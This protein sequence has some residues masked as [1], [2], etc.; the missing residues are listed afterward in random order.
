MVQSMTEKRKGTAGS[1]EAASDGSAGKTALPNAAPASRREKS[2]R[3]I[4]F[5]AFIRA[6]ALR[7]DARIAGS[8]PLTSATAPRI[9]VA[10]SSVTGSISNRM[11]PP[12]ACLAKALYKVSLPTESETA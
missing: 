1:L 9:T 3:C 2:R 5:F 10:T 12:S 6:A 4:E 7:S 8:I 11:S